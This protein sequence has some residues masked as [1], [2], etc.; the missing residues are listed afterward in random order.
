MDK[1]YVVF[2]CVENSCR[3]QMAEGFAHMLAPEG[4]E[5]FSSGSKVS[6][7]VNP[8][9]IVSM[10]EVGYDLSMQGSKS[11]DEIPQVKY[12]YAITMG[13]EDACPVVRAKNRLDWGIPDPKHMDPEKFAQVRDIIRNKV[14]EVFNL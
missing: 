9:A 10:A 8:K 14:K 6:G 12:E 1:K 5:I 13:C 2:I 11:L 4:W 3:S 7:K